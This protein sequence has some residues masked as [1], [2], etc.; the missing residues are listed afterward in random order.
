MSGPS[1]ATDDVLDNVAALKD[2]MSAGQKPQSDWRI[3]TEHEKFGFDKASLNPL[4]YEGPSGI[5]AMLNGLTRFDWQP[6]E[7]GGKLIALTRKDAAGGGSVTLEP[8]GQ[9]ELSGAPLSSIHETCKEVN[10]HLREVRE[11][12][13]ELGQGYLGVGFSPIWGLD[14]APHMPKGRYALMRDYMPTRGGRGLDMMYLSSTV[15]VNLDFGSEADMVEKLK[16]S[17]AVQ[18]IATALFS[19]SPFKN[20]KVTGDLSERSL[21]WMDTDPDRTGMLPI[22]FEEGFG[23]EQYVDYALDV[24]MYFV[25]RDG[26][27]IDAMGQSFRD[28]LAGNLPA[29]PGEKPTAKDWENHLTCLFP[30][31]RVKRFIEMRGADSGPWQ[32]LCALPAFWVGLLYDPATQKKVFDLI[33]DW[34]E[35]ERLYLRGQ[36]PH[37]G[38]KTKFRNSTVQEIASQLL[39]L[40]Q[41]G[42]RAR[43]KMD[44]M[45]ADEAGFLAPLFKTIRD[46][47][48][49]ADILVEK[50]HGEWQGDMRRIF[51]DNAF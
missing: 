44:S 9:L 18:P 51:V 17:L 16:V 37:T 26:Q 39:D 35:E 7:E 12:A 28:F 10:G 30:E 32:T 20:N 43:G 23:F 45:G 19:N 27:Y 6:V 8:G 15:Q 13:E 2:W 22:A 40:S 21:V 5:Q 50:Y 14:E 29:L 1:S 47:K 11:V 38:L 3:G 46:G 48:T 31:A 42:L 36:A 41:Q 4:P 33:S 24:P 25:F 34:T 49:P